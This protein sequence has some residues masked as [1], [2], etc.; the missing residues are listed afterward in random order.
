MKEFLR[1]ILL[2][3]ALFIFLSSGWVSY[4]EERPCPGQPKRIGEGEFLSA[5]GLTQENYSIWL[6]EH[7]EWRRNYSME[8]KEFSFIPQDF[9]T[10]RR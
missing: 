1:F 9:N 5:H 2:A 3:G 10:D 4:S 8:L 6:K 7:S